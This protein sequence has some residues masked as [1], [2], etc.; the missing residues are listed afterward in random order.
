MQEFLADR[1]GRIERLL[2][3]PPEQE[4]WPG[5]PWGR[6]DA[7]LSPAFWVSQAWSIDAPGAQSRPFG[8]GKDLGEEVVYCLL[9]GFGAPAE[10]GLAAAR[11]VN[12]AVAAGMRPEAEAIHRLLSRPLAVGTREVRYRFARLRAGYLASALQGLSDIDDGELDDVGLRDALKR[13]HGIGPKTASWIVRN[14]RS[15]D[16]VAILDVHVVRAGVA[17]GIFPTA[18]TPA[19]DYLGLERRFLEFCDRTCTRAS[20][21][22]AVIWS[23]MRAMGV[24]WHGR[25]VDANQRAVQPP[26]ARAG[27]GAHV[28][29]QRG[30]RGRRSSE[31][32]VG[33]GHLLPQA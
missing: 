20:N 17:M 23:T 11:R 19:N 24:E 32:F 13:L 6:F 21:L 33:S 22:D 9:G 31:R 8:L 12:D 2:L 3:P 4:V 14:H 5:L 7:I 18:R 10:V 25:I 28:G 30:A 26:V 29:K 27:E 1:Q 15:S 16:R